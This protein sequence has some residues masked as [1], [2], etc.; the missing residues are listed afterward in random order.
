V[1]RV[2]KKLISVCAPAYNESDCIGELVRRLGVVADALAQKYDFEFIICENGSSDDTFEKLLAARDR[3]PRVK[4]VR[5][6]RN[7]WAE[8]AL[9]AALAHAQGDA[10]VLMY[11]DLQDPP[12][13]IPEFVERWEEGYKNV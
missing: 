5:L 9:T 13:Y 7:F 2:D 10:A 12:E 4:I 11:S 3:D 1:Q 6:A 8:G